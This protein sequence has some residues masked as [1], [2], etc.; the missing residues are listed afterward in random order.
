MMD[1]T[2]LKA[3]LAKST[4]VVKWYPHAGGDCYGPEATVRGPCFRWFKVTEPQGNSPQHNIADAVD[5]AKYCAAA[6]N[7]VPELIR[8]L[9]S[10]RASETNL[11]KALQDIVTT[12]YVGGNGDD[13]AKIA[14]SVLE[15]KV[16]FPTSEPSMAILTK[17]NE[18]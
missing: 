3:F 8:E 13:C 17:Y 9:E 2:K 7:A 6:M 1:L 5:D 11:T 4:S 16:N 10:L 12:A 18:E 15:P 14:H